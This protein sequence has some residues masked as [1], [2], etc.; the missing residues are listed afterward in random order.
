[1]GGGVCSLG[2]LGRLLG[3]LWVVGSALPGVPLVKLKTSSKVV[4]LDM[5]PRVV[6]ESKVVGQAQTGLAGSCMAA[7]NLLL[8]FI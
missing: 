4:G 8:K 6:V 7:L 2:L 5:G 3:V 1:M